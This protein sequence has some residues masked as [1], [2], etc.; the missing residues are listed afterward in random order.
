MLMSLYRRPW[1]VRQ[2][3]QRL[4]YNQS[5]TLDAGELTRLADTILPF[6]LPAQK[7]TYIRYQLTI[8]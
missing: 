3:F 5:G 6:E 4:D 7:Q 1:Q 2:A 8:L